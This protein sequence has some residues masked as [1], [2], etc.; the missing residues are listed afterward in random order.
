MEWLEGTQR[1]STTTIAAA[2]TAWI[3]KNDLDSVPIG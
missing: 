1:Y 3:G 2:S